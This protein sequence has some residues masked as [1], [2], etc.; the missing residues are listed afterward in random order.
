MAATG[1]L[2]RI[3]K[4][5]GT[6]DDWLHLEHF[7][8]ANGIDVADKK[9]AVLLLVVGAES[10]KVLRNISSLSESG[11]KSYVELVALPKYFFPRS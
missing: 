11:E 4:F 10:Y 1:T 2:N 8:T 6:K 3:D 5:D 7:F 9:W